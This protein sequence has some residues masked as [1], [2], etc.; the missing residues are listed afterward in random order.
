V[1]TDFDRDGKVV[2]PVIDGD[3]GAAVLAALA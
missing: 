3:G 2:E 1:D